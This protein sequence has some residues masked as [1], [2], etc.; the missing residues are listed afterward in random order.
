MPDRV[1]GIA[2]YK[3]FKPAM[4]V[5]AHDDQVGVDF[6]GVAHDGPLRRGG[7]PYHGLYFDVFGPQAVG[8]PVQVPAARL[9]LRCGGKRAVNLAGYAFFDVDQE[10]LGPVRLRH[11]GGMGDS[12]AV[13]PG[14]VQG[15]QDASIAVR[16][17]RGWR[18][19]RQSHRRA[20][21][22]TRPA[23]DY[24]FEGN[25]RQQRSK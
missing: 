16:L 1:D 2:E 6:L 8:N 17:G 14:M 3:V 9:Y 15:Y 19:L 12:R 10:Y 18:R 25:P 13:K 5:C 22:A 4:A 11:G 21:E 20:T 24:R 7:V 23:G